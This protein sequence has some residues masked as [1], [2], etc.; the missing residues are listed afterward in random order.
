MKEIYLNTAATGRIEPQYISQAYQKYKKLTGNAS[1][2][3]E[4]WFEKELPKIKK[5]TADR[6]GA[7]G[8]EVA[9]IPNFS[10]G[11]NAVLNALPEN[12]N[13]LCYNKDY[14][15]LIDPL[16]YKNFNVFQFEDRDGFTIYPETIE[17]YIRKH[18]IDFL[19]LSHVQWLTG[20]KSD[21][22]EIGDICKRNSVR[23]IVDAT[24]SAG[25]N[26]ISFSN[27]EV[28][29]MLFSSYK[30]LNSGFGNGILL[31]KSTFLKD[32]PPKISGMHSYELIEGKLILEPSIRFYEPGHQNLFGFEI[33]K[34]V[35]ENRTKKDIRNIEKKN[36]KMTRYFFEILSEK[37][38]VI[39][40]RGTE[41]RSSIVYIE[42][43]EKLHQYM[44]SKG[45]VCSF[46]GGNVRISF[47][48]DNK[49]KEIDRAASIL[50]E[51]FK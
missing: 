48:F 41:H 39:G 29:A 12:S 28:D 13:V 33:F 40:I 47:H 5:L 35:L 19:V 7:A 6:F 11:I 37:V 15:S 14:P 49:K 4:K 10:F 2:F 25:A 50:N 46:R 3:A 18:F 36:S 51:Y 27:S 43:N 21:L 26:D 20:F 32:F 9:L 23:L 42:G 30:W 34:Q 38:P 1:V 24:Q 31:M 22:N 8:H 16:H 45:I 17:R 44:L